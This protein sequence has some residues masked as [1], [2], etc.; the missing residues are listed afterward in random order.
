MNPANQYQR[1]LVQLTENKYNT[2]SCLSYGLWSK[3]NPLSTIAQI[4]MYGLLDNHCFHLHNAIDQYSQS[5]NLIYYDCLD[6]VSRK[7]QKTILFIN[8]MDEQNRFTL[9]IDSFDYENTWYYLQLIV[10]PSQDIF[11]LIFIKRQVVQFEAINQMKYPF[12][13]ENLILSFGGNFIVRNSKILDVK[14]GEIFSYFPGTIILQDFSIQSL[15]ID[16]DFINIANQAYEQFEQCVCQSNKIFLIGDKNLKEQDQDIYISDN[17]NCDSFILVGWIKIKEIINPSGLLSYQLIKVSTNLQNPIFQNQ[18]LSPF[19]LLYH[20]TPLQNEIEITTYSYNFPDVSIDFSDNPFLMKKTLLIKNKIMLWHHLKVELQEDKLNVVITFYEGPEIFQYDVKFEVDQFHN[21]QFKI[22]FGNCQ[23][24]QINYLNTQMRNLQFFNCQK[25]LTTQNC[26]QSCYECDGPTNQD[27]LSCSIESQRIYIPEHKVCVCP[28]NTIDNQNKCQ[29]YKDSNLRLIEDKNLN[30]NQNCKYGFFELDGESFSPSMIKKDFLSC[31]E[32]LNNPKSWFKY[33]ICEKSLV[34]KLNTDYYDASLQFGDVQYYYDGIQLNPIHYTNSFRYETDIQ[35]ITNIFKEFQLSQNYFRQFCQQ[36]DFAETDQFICYECFLQ[37]CQYCQVTPTNFIC[38]KCYGNYELIDGECIFSTEIKARS[39]PVCLPPYY[40]S[41]ENYCKICEIKNCIYCFE[42]STDN[43]Q[44]CSLVDLLNMNL[45]FQRNVRTGCALCEQ[46]FIFDFTLELCLHQ[47]PQIKNCQRSYI[48]LQNKEECVSSTNDDFQIAPEISNCQDYIDNCQTCSLNVDLQIKCV[49]CQDK[50]MIENDQCYQNEEFDSQKISIYNQTNKI[51]SFILQFVP[52]LKQYVYNKFLNQSKPIIC[53]PNCIICDQTTTYCKQ[54]PLNYYKKYI[55]TLPS[56]LCLQ[57]HP[58]CQVCLQR[59]NKDIERDFPYLIVDDKSQNYTNKCIKPYNDP[60]FSFDPYLQSVRYCLTKDCKDHFFLDLPYQSCDFSRFNRFYESKINTDY[61]NQIGME[62][63]TIELVLNVLDQQ[64]FLILPFIIQTELKQKVFSLKRVNFKFSSQQYLEITSFTSNPFKNY[65]QVEISNLG[66]VLDADQHFIFYNSNKKIDLILKNFTI[67]QSILQNIDSLFQTEVFGNIT[68]NNF[69]IIDTTL[70]NSSLFNFHSYQM[71]GS[72]TITNL[73]IKNCTFI[74]SALFKLSQIESLLSYQ[75]L[76]MQQCNLTKSSIFSFES[77][78]QNQRT[79]TG[80]NTMI[81]NNKFYN[82]QLINST[83]LIEVSLYNFKLSLNLMEN[84]IMISVNYNITMSL[85]SIDQNVFVFSQFLSI[86]QIQLRNH[87]QCNITNFE[88]NENQFQGSSLI[89][90]FS[91]LSTNFLLIE[92]YQFKI[93]N[94]S[95]Y[96]IHNENNPLFCINSQEIRISNFIIFDND[97]LM[98]FQLS[99]N[100]KISISNVIFQNTIQNFKIP[101]SQSCLI[102]NKKNK[103]LYVSG[104]TTIYIQNL[105]ISKIVSVDEPLIQINPSYQN[106][107]YVMSYVEMINITFTHNILIQSTLVNQISLLI[108]ESEYRESIL[109]ENIKFEENFLHS[110]S[111]SA[112][113]ATVSLLYIQTS[114]SQTKVENFLSKNNALTNSSNSFIT[115]MSAHVMLSNFSIQNHNFLSQQLWVKYYELIF[116]ENLHQDNLNQIIFQILQIKNIGGAGSFLVQNIS[117][118]NCSFSKILATQSLI[119]EITTTEAGCIDLQNITIDQVENNPQSTEKGSGCFSIYS[120]NSKLNLRLVNA[121]LSNIFNRMASLIFTITP[122]KSQN[123]ILF[124]DT[125]ITNCISLL[126]QIINIQFSSLIANKNIVTI[127]NI[128]ITQNLQVWTEYFTKVRDISIQEITET[129]NNQNS[130]ISLQNCITL[131]EDFVIEGIIVNSIFYFANLPKLKLNNVKLDKISVLYS[132]NLIQVMQFSQIK[133]MIVIENLSIK[134]IQLYQNNLTPYSTYSQSMYNIRG[135]KIVQQFYETYSQ[136][137]FYSY[138][139]SIQSNDKQ[140]EGSFI[141]IQSIS[142]SNGIYF[143]DVTFEHNNCQQCQNGL[144]FFEL[145]DIQFIKLDNFNCNYNQINKFG[146][147]H[148]SSNT[149]LRQKVLIKNSNFLFNNGTQGIG[150]YSQ[151]VSLSIKLCKLINN[152]ALDFGGGLYIDIESSDFIV[153]RSIII[154]NIAKTGGGI[155]LEGNCNLNKNNF[156]LSQLLF[157]NALEYAN[158]VIEIP[159]HLA[160]YI[161]KLENPSQS[162]T[163][164]NQSINMLN[165]KPYRMI[166]QG[167]QIN[168]KDLLI[169]SNQVIKTFQIFDIRQSKYLPLIKDISLAY[170]NSRNEVMHNFIN[171]TC[172]VKDKIITKD[173]ME[174]TDR[175]IQKTLF[176]DIQTNSFDFGSLSFS[177]DPYKQDYDYLQI[178]ISCQLKEQKDTLKYRI[179]ARSLKCQLGEFYV[180]NGCQ[181]CQ[182]NQG[183]YSV[184]Y[185]A[186]KCSIFDK[187]K[188]SDIT[189]NMIQLLPGFWRP[190]NFSDYVEYCFKNK[191]F[192]IGGWQVGDYTCS[193]GHIGALCEECDRYGIRGQGNFYKNQWDQNCRECRFDWTSIF[194]TT[195]ICLWYFDCYQLQDIYINLDVFKKYLQI[196]LTI[197]ITHN[198]IKIQQNIIQTKLRQINQ[199]MLDQESIQLKMLIN[200][201]WIYSVIFTFNIRFSFSLLFIE[202]SSDT[203]YF[204]AKDLDC[205]I[206]SIQ[207][208]P[209]VQLKIFTMLILMIILFNLIIAGQFLHTLITKQKHDISI[210]SNSALYLYVFNYA[211]LIKMFSSVLSKREVSNQNYIQGDVSLKYGSPVHL[212]WVYYFI[213]PGIFIIGIFVPIL[214]FI[215]L[216]LNRQKLD[217]IK[218]RKHLCYL[219]NEYKQERYYWELIKLFKKSVIIFIMTNFET[220]IVLKA[221]L[222]GLCL[223]IYEI[224]AIFHQPFTIQ[225]Y[226]S[227]DLQTAQICSISMF[228]ALTKSICEQ[229]NYI[230]PSILIQIL[231]IGCFIKLCY[232]FIFG[233]ARSYVKKYQFLYLNK[234][235]FFLNSKVPNIYFALIL[236]KFLEREKLKQQKLK[237]NFTKLK[238][239][240]IFLSKQQLRTSKQILTNITCGQVISPQSSRILSTKSS[241]IGVEKA[242]F[243]NVEEYENNKK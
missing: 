194:P 19:Q 154:G 132:F 89:L 88:A 126:N 23:Q 18:N 197:F 153:N 176:F 200:Y 227:L 78:Y 179:Y 140:E 186:T 52:K 120:S 143:Q 151:K 97:D 10:Q 223:L 152:T 98:I 114:L 232:P 80:L 231:I 96:S 82:S 180:D 105:H 4:G 20:I 29:T 30:V 155:Y 209:I 202:Q 53:D 146:C 22:E 213:I 49:V 208:I 163:N 55:I 7:I 14:D 234:L 93:I 172:I 178:D 65:D 25:E 84:S 138:V 225:K 237:S 69:T 16:F 2:D 83:L 121:F 156:V 5:L 116:N 17:I 75:Y 173:K 144:V 233:I 111:S 210:L 241:R 168:M 94:N 48:N 1:K 243:S 50:F 236:G 188:Y 122:S 139:N 46:N 79:L 64:C 149:Y 38:V 32:C 85:I 34:I 142:N 51:Q 12:K 162:V 31:V 101:L 24:T 226:N 44:F 160:F 203:S 189:S 15:A 167:S 169:P 165:L 73:Q 199:Q 124:Q 35:N 106:L 109:L 177:L 56:K 54:C 215:L 141:Y 193:F 8:N 147:L 77:N 224:L 131:I 113:M 187:G 3:Y 229:K 129:I 81:L 108:I 45:K 164:N 133:S 181:I 171:S 118:I 136:D 158:N 196:Q 86:N 99:E 76:Q 40:Y 119:F 216:K 191:F 70:I 66:F 222:L 157:N 166:E 67:T 206:S 43:L 201:L 183:Y 13:D 212:Q 27:C 195:I 235:H 102:T 104:F 107:S 175:K 9:E 192:C 36:K 59:S 33:P 161:N 72:I 219:L 174:I 115:V 238:N 37:Y 190:N 123:I 218:L 117:C 58:L 242:F 87:I 91:T 68:L 159:N 230:F 6:S 217:K 26:H 185:N 11:K 214:I 100:N 184:T 240:L 42:Y 182:S 125:N 112:V 150:I 205:Y 74:E 148:F 110:Y 170:K 137:Y 39:K 71:L 204:I 90:V 211:G 135:C 130:L 134:N 62:I 92:F 60:S 103:L 61:C 239:H 21:C 228:L 47:I 198:C 128:R 221:S 41:F 63:L 28:F 127:K 57:C 95:K 145:S 220:E 207:N